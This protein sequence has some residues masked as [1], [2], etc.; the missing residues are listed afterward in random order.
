MKKTLPYVAI[1]G[2]GAFAGNMINIGLSYGIHWQSLGPVEFMDVFAVDFPLLLYPTSATL[3][4]ALISTAL[5]YFVHTKGTAERRL[6][7]FALLGLMTV[8]IQT[9]AY[10]LPINLGITAKSIDPSRIGQ[11]LMTWLIFHWI[12]VGFA[13]LSGV[14]AISALIKGIEKKSK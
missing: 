2:I 9:L 8:N 5:L 13:I 6:W 1:I 4:P 11:V 14:F 12:R 10:H 7:L 3:L